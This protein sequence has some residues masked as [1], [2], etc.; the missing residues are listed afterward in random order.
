VW[1][2]VNPAATVGGAKS[3]EKWVSSALGNTYLVLIDP[4]RLHVTIA[5]EILMLRMTT[6]K[7]HV[8]GDGVREQ[9]R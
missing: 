4:R 6:L 1:S 9:R 8:H 3:G 5:R 2:I 7:K